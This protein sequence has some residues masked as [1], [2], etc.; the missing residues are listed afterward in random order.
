MDQLLAEQQEKLPNGVI[1]VLD[2]PKITII[3]GLPS[4]AIDIVRAYL[5]GRIGVMDV[6]TKL[7]GIRLKSAKTHELLAQ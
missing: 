2:A 5:D 1:G 7:D 3:D 4:D 6:I